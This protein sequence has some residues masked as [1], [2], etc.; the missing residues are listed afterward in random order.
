MVALNGFLRRRRHPVMAIAPSKARIDVTCS[1]QE[2]TEACVRA[3]GEFI[4]KI[5]ELH[6]K[7]GDGMTGS[8]RH[9][10]DRPNAA[11]PNDDDQDA[12]GERM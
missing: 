6:S 11:A 7:G 1:A 9:R 2:D 4:D 10:Q 12:P 3:A 5:A 8:A